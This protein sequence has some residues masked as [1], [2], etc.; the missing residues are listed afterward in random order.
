M[1]TETLTYSNCLAIYLV[2]NVKLNN[3]LMGTETCC[4]CH[5]GTSFSA[6]VKLNHPLMGTETL[7]FLQS[8]YIIKHNTVKLNHP[9]MGTE[10]FPQFLPLLLVDS[11]ELVKLNHPPMGTETYFVELLDQSVKKHNVKLN[12]PHIRGSKLLSSTCYILKF[13]S[14]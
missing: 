12:N 11:F 9:L 7:S 14:E 1:G 6:C 3:P 10:T 4:C 8:C 2:I 13:A 5:N